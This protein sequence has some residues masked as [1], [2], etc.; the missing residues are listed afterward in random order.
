MFPIFLYGKDT[1]YV[2]EGNIGFVLHPVTK[3]SRRET[4][5]IA[6]QF[7][8]RRTQRSFRSATGFE[9]A[10]VVDFGVGLCYT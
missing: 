8:F 5:R 10:G 1:G 4:A 3:E 7:I 6:I 9:N 2:G